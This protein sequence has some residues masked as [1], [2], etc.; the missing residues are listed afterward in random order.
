MKFPGLY[1]FEKCE[2][3]DVTYQLDYNPEGI[4]IKPN[5]SRCSSTAAGNICKTS[6][7]TA[8]LENPRQRW[9]ARKKYFAMMTLD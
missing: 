1:H 4:A 6:R 9:M 5:I 2:P 7:D 3:E 8:T